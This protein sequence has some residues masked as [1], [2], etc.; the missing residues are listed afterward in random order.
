MNSNGSVPRIL[1]GEPVRFSPRALAILRS[2]G[3]VETRQLSRDNLAAAFSDYDVV[4]VR[5]ANRVTPEILGPAPRCRILVTATTGLD[6]IDVDSCAERG[7]SVMSLRGE[8]E[9]LKEVR[10]TAEHTIAMLLALLRR[11]PEAVDSV[12]GGI[13]DRDRFH[14]RELYGKTAGVAG[15]GR[16]GQIVARYYQAFGM[17]VLAYDPYATSPDPGVQLVSTLQEL[18]ASCD[19]LSIHVS[20]SAA[21]HGLINSA[22]FERINRGAVLV[23]TARGQ[24]VDELALLGALRSGLLAGAALDVLDGEPEIDG[25]HPLVEYAR[26]HPQLLITPHIGGNTAES[27]EKTEVFLAR[28]VVAAISQQARING[29]DRRAALNAAP[30]ARG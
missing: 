4:W 18:A 6:H 24:V 26:E 14:G 13:W 2:A 3:S 8:H 29:D 20:Y 17:R 10:A 27:F 7:I 12:R 9:F 16:I 23:N 22:V 21:T 30:P 5:L 25:A 11:I 15:L 19:V 1:V 28:K